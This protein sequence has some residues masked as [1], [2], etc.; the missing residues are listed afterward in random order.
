MD[1]L[2]GGLTLHELIG[3]LIVYLHNAAGKFTSV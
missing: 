2:Y 1:W 3:E